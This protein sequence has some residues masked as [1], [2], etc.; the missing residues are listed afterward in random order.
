MAYPFGYG[1]SYSAFKYSDLNVGIVG[2]EV[3]VEY[4]ITNISGTDGKE[5]SQVYVGECAPLVYR[6]KKELKAFSKDLIKAGETQRIKIELLKKD[7]AYYSI[8]DD[9]WKVDDGIFQIT[10]GPSSDMEALTVIVK[11]ENGKLHKL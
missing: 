5:V 11:V 7:F 8:A 4:N 9:G 3:V 1:L 6:P 10:V 2:D